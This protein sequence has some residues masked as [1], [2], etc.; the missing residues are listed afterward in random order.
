VGSAPSPAD[1]GRSAPLAGRPLCFQTTLTKCKVRAVHP[2]AALVCGRREARSRRVL[3]AALIITPLD[4]L[5]SGPIAFGM[6]MAASGPDDL[7]NT[8]N[9]LLYIL[10]SVLGIAIFGLVGALA[11]GYERRA[12]HLSN[13]LAIVSL[14]AG[15]SILALLLFELLADFPGS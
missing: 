15:S 5:A 6:A 1:V 12:V 7:A 2:V 14:A 13:R 4:P 8:N 10:A 3:T 9:P 11:T